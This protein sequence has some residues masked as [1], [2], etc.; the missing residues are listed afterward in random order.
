[1]A[2]I[3]AAWKQDVPDVL[4]DGAGAGDAEGLLA[5]LSLAADDVIEVEVEGIGILRNPVTTAR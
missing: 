3:F 1:L 2:P 5:V 4:P